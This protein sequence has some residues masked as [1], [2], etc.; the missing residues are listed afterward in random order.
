MIRAL[1]AA[2]TAAPLL[3]AHGDA[4]W[5]MSDPV[6]AWCCGPHDCGQVPADFARP[7]PG[8]WYIPSTGQTFRWGERG[9]YPSHDGIALWRCEAGGSVRCLFVP[10]SG[11]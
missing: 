3:L 8:G 9:L 11:V 6:T 4:E 10:G 1:V 7:V 5:I 2:V